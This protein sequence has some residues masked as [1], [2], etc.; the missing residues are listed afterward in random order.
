[1]K[2]RAKR[3]YYLLITIIILSTVVLLSIGY[4]S[5]K[6]ELAITNISSTVR[7]DKDIRV[8]GVKLNNSNKAS[9]MYEDYNV[10]NISFQGNLE[11]ADSYLIYDVDVYN[12]GNV[13]MGIKSVDINNENLKVEILNYNLKD[14]ICD[15]NNK[16]ILGI[17]KKLQ[18]KVAYKEG[19]YSSSNTSFNIRVDFIFGRIYNINYNDIDSTNLPSEIIEGD[20]LVVNIPPRTGYD[21]KVFMNGK[22]LTLD[23]D[24][25][26]ENDT[27]TIFNVDGDIKMYYKMPICQ[28]AT[29]LHQEECFGNYCAGLGYKTDGSMQTK[30]ISYGSLGET[31]KLSSGDAFDCDVDGDGVYD[32]ATERFYYVTD[33]DN[34]TAV[35]IYYNNVSGGK[36]S[37]DK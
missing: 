22:R 23:S 5:F 25:Q 33:M 36:P 37:N 27:L 3:N 9:S 29:V 15:D 26:Y 8:M 18:V 28:R 16:C 34:D 19:S 30:M 13:I 35:L 1:M 32:S 10:A 24:Y 14:K 4:S 31:G 6:N 2:R 21:L 7:I 11:E 20:K 17:E 12:L